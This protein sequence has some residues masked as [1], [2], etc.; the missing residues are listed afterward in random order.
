MKASR[1]ARAG[2]G[3]P[4][5]GD[6]LIEGEEREYFLKLLMREVPPGEPSPASSRA[7]QPVEDKKNPKGE[8]APAKGKGKKKSK[9]KVLRGYKAAV[10]QPDGGKS[11]GQ[12]EEENTASQTSS[13]EK[14]TAPDPLC[15]PEARGRGLIGGNQTVAKS[16][17]ES[18]TTSRGECSGQKKPDP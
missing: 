9:K 2:G 15:N 7:D 18:T 8:T 13:Q 17:S 14:S 6:L 3:P 11:S 16:R 12:R 1:L 5:Q 4:G 10:A